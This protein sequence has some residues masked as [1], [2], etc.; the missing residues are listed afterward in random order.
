MET[1]RILLRPWRDAEHPAT[2]GK[3]ATSFAM[4]SAFSA[5]GAFVG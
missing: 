3:S 1:E 5:V 2:D 4:A